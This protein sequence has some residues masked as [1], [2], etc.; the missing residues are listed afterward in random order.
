MQQIHVWE[1]NSQSATQIPSLLWNPKVHY[2]VHKSPPLVPILSHMNPLHNFPPSLPK[3]HS[4]FMLPSTPRSSWVVFS[5]IEYNF[6]HCK[7]RD[8]SVRIALGYGLDDRGSRIL[9]P[10]GLGIFLFTTASRMALGLTQPPIQRVQRTLS[11]RVKRPGREAD[12]SHPSS[13]EVKECVE[14]YL[15]SWRGA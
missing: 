1:T 6:L 8:S 14:L 12:H 10:A 3:I 15:H 7:N 11:L 2:R 5:H 4:D 13:D 9:F